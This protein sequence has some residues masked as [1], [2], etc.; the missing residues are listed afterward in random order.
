MKKIYKLSEELRL[1]NF[2]ERGYW[3]STKADASNHYYADEGLAYVEF[4]IHN[5]EATEFFP[6]EAGFAVRAVRS[7]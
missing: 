7:F 4:F 2:N 1:G 6:L 5:G 3:T